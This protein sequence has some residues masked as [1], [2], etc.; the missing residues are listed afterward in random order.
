[1]NMGS[2]NDPRRDG[3]LELARR[4]ARR[5]FLRGTAAGL[6]GIAL[7]SLLARDLF[8]GQEAR[9]AAANPLLARAPHFAPKAKSVI[10]LFMNGGP[11][12]LDLFDPKPALAELDGKPCPESFLRGE[13]FAFGFPVLQ[14]IGLFLGGGRELADHDH[15]GHA[16]LAPCGVGV[17]HRWSP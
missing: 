7:S 4:L 14:L 2:R 5:E 1:M 13:R 6:G 11:S 10:W 8:A 17:G 9:T 12:H 3:E 15:F 16:D